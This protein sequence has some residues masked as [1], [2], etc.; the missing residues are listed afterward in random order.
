M[1]ISTNVPE[2]DIVI[3]PTV[4]WVKE[5]RISDGKLYFNTETNSQSPRTGS[6]VLSYDDQYQRKAT[7]TINLSQ[8]Y[9]E[10]ANA[11]LVSYPTVYGYPVGGITNN[12]YMKE[13]SLP[14]VHR[15]TSRTI[16][17]SFRMRPGRQWYLN[18]SL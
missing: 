18:Q 12:V 8:A 4:E 7:T 5:Y 17:M 15:K 14:L 10:Y 1:D 2:T 6:I 3:T 11:E 16:V 13:R 9:S